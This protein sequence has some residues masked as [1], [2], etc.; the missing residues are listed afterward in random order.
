VSLT[1][2]IYIYIYI[3]IYIAIFAESS[4]NAE[5]WLCEVVAVAAGLFSAVRRQSSEYFVNAP[6][7]QKKPYI[8]EINPRFYQTLKKNKDL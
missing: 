2:F 3:Y 5:V 6:I 8:Y 7:E 4:V 1:V